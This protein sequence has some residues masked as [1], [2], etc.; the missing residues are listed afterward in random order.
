MA[1]RIRDW[2]KTLRGDASPE[3][4][5]D[6]QREPTAPTVA[7]IPTAPS[8][9]SDIELLST[10]LRRMGV[11]DARPTHADPS[12]MAALQRL[13]QAGAQD[14]AVRFGSALVSAI[15]TDDELALQVAGWLF[16]QGSSEAAQTLLDR[17][18]IPQNA[19]QNDTTLGPAQ[20]AIVAQARLLRSE[21][22]RHLGDAAGSRADLADL[23]IAD[24]PQSESSPTA[25]ALARFRQGRARSA[26]RGSSLPDPAQAWPSSLAA[27][28]APTLIGESTPSRYRVLRE[29]GA[30]ANGVVYA[31]LDEQLGC[32]LAL[33]R[34][35]PRIDGHHILDE[36]KLLSALQH[37]GVL[38]LYDFDLEGRFLTMELCRGGSLRA[39]IRREQ[40]SVPAVLQRLRELCDA[41]AAVHACA[42]FHGDIKP[43]N[44]LFRDPTVSL[45]SFDCDPA[46]GDLVLSDFGIAERIAAP[47]QTAQPTLR[48]TRAYLAPERLHGQ[49]GSQAADL[50]SVGVVLFELL[51]AELPST[52]IGQAPLTTDLAQALSARLDASALLPLLGALLSVDP[53]R[54]PTASQA[55]DA[56][57][58]L[59]TDSALV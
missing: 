52:P 42:L 56:V 9:A 11:L 44:L 24:W 32:E 30:G 5:V 51:C 29:L 3:S 1:G 39:R 26:Q 46:F 4:R 21:V 58:Q 20:A 57:D 12:W 14:A 2:L 59:L 50:Y 15:P 25:A 31:V 55:R 40:L 8:Q 45:R 53:S 22:R 43:E 16:R 10:Q 38:A 18:L 37:P 54:R 6:P 7:P 17:I 36:A 48:G 27:T 47:G 34:F 19:G 35:D 13:W 23:L 33:K 28:A 41:L 49:P